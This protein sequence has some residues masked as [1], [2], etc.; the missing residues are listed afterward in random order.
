MEIKK[1]PK[2]DLESRKSINVLTGLVGILAILFIAFEWSTTE[3]RKSNLAARALYE[4][5]GFS[6]IGERKNYYKD[7]TEDACLYRRG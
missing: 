3:V 6:L 4:K 1:D 2:A 7:P 5:L